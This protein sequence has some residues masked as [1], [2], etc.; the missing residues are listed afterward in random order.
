[1]VATAG[2]ALKVAEM[3]QQQHPQQTASSSSSSTGVGVQQ[4]QQ[5]RTLL[6]PTHWH[7]SFGLLLECLLLAPSPDMA[8]SCLPLMTLLLQQMN[9]A[10]QQHGSSNED[11]ILCAERNLAEATICGIAG[12]AFSNVAAAVHCCMQR[13]AS[14]KQRRRLLRLWAGLLMM[15]MR[16]AGASHACSSWC[17]KNLLGYPSCVACALYPHFSPTMRLEAGSYMSL[18][19]T[20]CSWYSSRILKLVLYASIL[21]QPI[22][23]ATGL[24]LQAYRMSLLMCI[25]PTVS[26]QLD[27][28]RCE[29]A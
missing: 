5:L 15:L 12:A 28:K 21:S 10:L 16:G 14:L 6:E 24:L 1:M 20:C 17:C 26:C 9:A 2:D 19:G 13:T 3:W 4:G 11:A 7:A 22:G 27:G 23:L 29:G 18:C 8:S 25:S